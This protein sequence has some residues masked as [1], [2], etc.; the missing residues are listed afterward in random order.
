MVSAKRKRLKIIFHQAGEKRVDKISEEVGEKMMTEG[1]GQ[2]ISA[3]DG[4]V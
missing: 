4:W 2:H 3:N 1:R